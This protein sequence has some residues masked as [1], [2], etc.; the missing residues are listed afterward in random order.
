MCRGGPAGA[1][2]GIFSTAG[3]YNPAVDHDAGDLTWVHYAPPVIGPRRRSSRLGRGVALGAVAGLASAMS[4]LPYGLALRDEID[5]VR[6]A[7]LS[8]A[9]VTLLLV[10]GATL[11]GAVV[12]GIGSADR[13]RGASSPF[14]APLVLALAA[15][16]LAAAP[17]AVGTWYFGR[18]TLP[19]LGNVAT[20]AIPGIMSFGI[21]IGT[22]WLDGGPRRGRALGRAVVAA[23]AALS[24]IAF[25]FALLFDRVH[26]D[27]LL[28]QLRQFPLAPLGGVLGGGLG[29]LYGAYAGGV[30]VIARALRRRAARA[31]R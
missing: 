7:W 30:V 22:A 27:E 9:F 31:A 24:P 14:A 2:R 3:A 17:G 18:L 6:W 13:W 10:T 21:A 5:P 4:A 19:Y 16:V 25:G 26:D 28:A 23:V 20:F 12:A 15:G 29:V 1:R 8:G 11:G